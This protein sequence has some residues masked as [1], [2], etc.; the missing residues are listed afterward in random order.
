VDAGL[1]VGVLFID[2]REAFDSVSHPIL[3]KKLSSCGV[4]GPFFSYFKDYLSN[5]N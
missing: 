3:L 4:S 2:F 5:R 1:V